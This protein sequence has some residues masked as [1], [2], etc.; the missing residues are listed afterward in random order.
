MKIKLNGNVLLPLCREP[1]E[2]TV[3]FQNAKGAFN[4]Y[5]LQHLILKKCTK[6]ARRDIALHPSC[7]EHRS[8][9]L[10]QLNFAAEKREGKPF[11]VHLHAL[12]SLPIL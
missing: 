5:R 7:L 8:L 9:F 1:S 12:S 3:V 11:R 6:L 10:L 4:L 2:M